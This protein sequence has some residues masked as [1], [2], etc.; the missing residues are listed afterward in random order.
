MGAKLNEWFEKGTMEP[1]YHEM[2]RD[3]SRL[4]AGHF[5]IAELDFKM[6]DTDSN[7]ETYPVWAVNDLDDYISFI[8]DNRKVNY[9]T[10]TIL[11]GTDKGQKYLKFTLQVIDNA[12]LE[13][14]ASNVK[15][16]TT[17]VNRLHFFALCDKRVEENHFNI[18]VVFNH[19]KAQLVKYQFASDLKMLN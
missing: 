4:V 19:V 3:M 14:T 6:N 5:H 10:T 11:L 12:E 8:H 17:G 9:G 2:L 15:H 1:G 16:K 7:L 18:G 13:G